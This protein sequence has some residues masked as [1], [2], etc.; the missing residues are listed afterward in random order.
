ME[1]LAIAQALYNAVGE[2]VSTK[3]PDSLR[4]EVDDQMRA[5]YMA[6]GAKTFDVKVGDV[7]VGSF[8]VVTTKPAEEKVDESFGVIDNGALFAWKVPEDM[9]HGYARDNIRDFARWYF[10][11]TGE[12]PPGCAIVETRTPADPG[13]RVKHTRISVD[14]AKVAEALGG[15]LEGAAR[16]LLEGGEL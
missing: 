14:A 9:A 5:L 7:K 4:A 11:E 3:K 1:R 15:E 10:E 16:A 6:T 2:A 12:M 13:G 8:S